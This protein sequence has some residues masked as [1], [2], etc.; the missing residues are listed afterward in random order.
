[1]V[2]HSRQ[3]RWLYGTARHVP[4]LIA[5]NPRTAEKD[6]ADLPPAGSASTPEMA[7]GVPP[8]TT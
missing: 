8:A 7:T 4:I 2:L 1:M 3:Q 5:F 6:L